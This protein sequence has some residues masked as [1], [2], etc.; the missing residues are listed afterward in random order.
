MKKGWER[1]KPE[2]ILAKKEIEEI[3][4]ELGLILENYHL[5]SGGL[6]HTNYKVHVR[7]KKE[8]VV[9]RLSRDTESLQREENLHA[10]FET[11]SRV[12]RFFHVIKKEEYTAGVIEWKEGILLRDK[13][14]NTDPQEKEEMGFSI[15]RLIASCRKVTFPHQGFLDSDLNVTEEFT[16]TPASYLETVEHFILDRKS[17]NWLEREL[18]DS[19]LKECR[20]NASILEEDESGPSLVHGDMNG[21]NILMDGVEVSALLDWEFTMSGSI[22]FDLGNLIRYD[23]Y[24]DFSRFEKGMAKGLQAGGIRLP[25]N[26][27]KIAR[28]T[29]LLAL[30][31]ML[32]ND[33]GGR[34]RVNDITMLIKR[35]VAEL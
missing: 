18:T 6:S 30:I 7:N 31:T 1:H 15:G 8:P 29:D 4:G 9:L 11:D 25:D 22:Y 19:I 34:N 23:T 3:L 32:D 10:L 5:L 21:L 14:Q 16:L 2:I 17:G 26:W 27:R 33:L 13:L 35:T 20:L 24:K 28:L 12:P